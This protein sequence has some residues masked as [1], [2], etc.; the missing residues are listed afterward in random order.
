MGKTMKSYKFQVLIV[1]N[2]LSF[3][4]KLGLTPFYLNS[5]GFQEIDYFSEGNQR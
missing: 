5:I 1:Y 3:P 4:Q 2:F